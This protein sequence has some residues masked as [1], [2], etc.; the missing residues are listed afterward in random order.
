MWPPRCGS[1]VE[2]MVP[3]LE[4]AQQPPLWAAHAH[5]AAAA[6]GDLSD[7]VVLIG[8]ALLAVVDEL[9]RH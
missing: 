3:V 6:L 2:A 1:A 7:A 8:Q 9:E 5:S 4:D